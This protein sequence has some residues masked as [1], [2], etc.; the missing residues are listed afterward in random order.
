MSASRVICIDFEPGIPGREIAAQVAHC[1]EIPL[2][3]GEIISK[4]AAT[5][6]LSP[7]TVISLE[8]EPDHPIERWF[9][10]AGEGDQS[11]GLV[12]PT[13]VQS[14]PSMQPRPPLMRAIRQAIQE[15]AIQPCVI[16][17]HDG[18]YALQ[19]R[20]GAIRVFLRAPSFCRQGWLDQQHEGTRPEQKRTVDRVDEGKRAYIKQAYGR[21]WPDPRIYH[22]MIDVEGL[23]PDRSGLLVAEYAISVE[24]GQ[25]IT[26]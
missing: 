3:D 11:F 8:G 2:L 18:A 21:P 12:G 19:D 25:A 1:L 5:L 26:R 13:T 9:L 4:A 23:R 16:V 15:L 20:A 14:D 24:Q 22:F 10:A 7:R 17:D 6:N